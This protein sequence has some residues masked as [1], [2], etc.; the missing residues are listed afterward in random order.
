[1]TY[2]ESN[3]AIIEA[4]HQAERTFRRLAADAVERQDFIE[5]GRLVGVA[6]WHSNFAARRETEIEH[7]EQE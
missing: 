3:K 1:M 2:A 7:D 4:C 5:S 6:E